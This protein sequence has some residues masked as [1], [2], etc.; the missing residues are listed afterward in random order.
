M[1][2]AYSSSENENGGEK[3]LLQTKLLALSKLYAG[4]ARV[5]KWFGKMERNEGAREKSSV[6]ETK[7]KKSSR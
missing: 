1:Q 4:R 6:R 2:K 7:G 3:N 5:L